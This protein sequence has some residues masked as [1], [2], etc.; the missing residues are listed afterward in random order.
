MAKL[1]PDLINPDILPELHR[2]LAGLI[3]LPATL[4]LGEAYNGV[5]LYVPIQVHDD[6]PLTNIVGADAFAALV[7]QYGG[8]NLMFPKLDAAARQIK[9]QIIAQMTKKQCS[10]KDIALNTGYSQRRV[11]QIRHEQNIQPLS[12]DQLSM[13]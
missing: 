3:G 11:L 5:Y 8:S 10:V 1:N 6:H 13:F 12:I 7:D 9:Y 2:E 4:E